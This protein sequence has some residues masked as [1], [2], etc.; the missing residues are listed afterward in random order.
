MISNFYAFLRYSGVSPAF[1][2]TISKF[3]SEEG[4]MRDRRSNIFIGLLI[5]FVFSSKHIIIYNEEILVVLS[6][7]AFIF[8]SSRM[9]NESIENSL[10]ERSLA[11]YTELQNSVVLKENLL[12]ELVGEH[13]KQLILHE[14]LTGLREFF[15]NELYQ[16]SI[17]REKCLNFVLVNQ[18]QQK[19]EVLTFSQNITQENLQTTLLKGFRGSLLEEF[20][21]SKKTLKS[22]LL[23]QAIRAS[24]IR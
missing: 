23:Q 2:A 16:I 11:I 8:F 12:S 15:L 22:K 17:K 10:N 24:Y 9:L 1:I 20:Y 3:F 14:F 6:F 18:L 21:V 7:L 5:F 13:K 4:N 19:L